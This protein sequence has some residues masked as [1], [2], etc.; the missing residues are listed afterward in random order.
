MRG[1]AGLAGLR[2]NDRYF[3]QYMRQI[4]TIFQSTDALWLTHAHFSIEI[5]PSSKMATDVLGRVRQPGGRLAA[6]ALETWAV[7]L[8]GAAKLLE[9]SGPDPDKE[10]GDNVCEETSQP[11]R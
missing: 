6:G 4:V 2:K 11:D 3:W 7:R 9:S 1:R 10:R 5:Y 8:A